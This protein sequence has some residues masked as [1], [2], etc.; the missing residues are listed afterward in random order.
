MTHVASF[1]PGRR[2]LGTYDYP[3]AHRLFELGCFAV[4]GVLYA[5]VGLRVVTGLVAHSSPSVLGF[6]VL[7]SV[8]AYAT[9][10][11]MSGVV[12][13]LFD[14]C[15]SPETR[16]IGAKF[17]A[18][19]RDHHVD[20]MAMTRGDFIAVNGDNLFVCIPVLTPAVAVLDVRLHTSL[21][22]YLFAL[23]TAI[24]L[25][26]QIHKWAHLDHVPRVVA[27][28]QQRGIILSK[29]RHH[30]HHTAPYTS[31]YCI[32]W[33][34]LNPLLNGLIRRLRTWRSRGGHQCHLSGQ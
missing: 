1:S 33:G 15:W 19:F 2:R 29:Q 13:L 16:L 32:T 28:A 5:I 25:T 34:R 30:V 8:G 17:V 7:A 18:S 14:T 6:A 22:T 27:A 11:L 4:G 20:P 31:D 10:D 12:H 23:V 21:G 9:A 3:A 26:N 24:M